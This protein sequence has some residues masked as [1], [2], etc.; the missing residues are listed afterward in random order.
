MLY[1]GYGSNLNQKNFDERT[2]RKRPAQK[3]ISFKEIAYLPDYRPAYSRKTESGYGALDIVKEPGTVTLG[4]LFEVDDEVIPA[5]EVKEGVGSNCYKKLTVT[6]ITDSGIVNAE[7]YEV[8]EKFDY[9]KPC[10]EY[11]EIVR[12]GMKDHHFPEWWIK[13]MDDAAENKEKAAPIRVF[14]YGTLRKG[15][16]LAGSLANCTRTPAALK[17]RLYDLGW[18]PGIYL[19]ENGIE[20][21]GEIVEVDAEQLIKLDGIEGFRGYDGNSLYHRIWVPEKKLNL[22]VRDNFGGCWVYTYNRPESELKPQSLVRSGDWFK[23]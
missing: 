13:K 5:L 20:I 4:G 11:V 6:V 2:A 3:T 9:V 8:V 16:C 15:G 1:F 10:S 22:K 19:D 12:Q 7:T 18:Y 14:V 21:V 17:G 23:K